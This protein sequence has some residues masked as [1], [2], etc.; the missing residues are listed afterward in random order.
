MAPDTCAVRA[1]V[2]DIAFQ[3]EKALGIKNL[4]KKSLD[5]LVKVCSMNTRPS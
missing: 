4:P 1:E 3:F 5:L 2:L